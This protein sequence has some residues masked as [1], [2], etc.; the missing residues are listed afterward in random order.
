[1]PSERAVSKIHAIY[2]HTKP[3]DGRATQCLESLGIEYRRRASQDDIGACR[4]L[5]DLNGAPPWP[6]PEFDIAEHIELDVEIDE[7]GSDDRHFGSPSAHGQPSVRN[8]R[9]RG[10]GRRPETDSVG[11]YASSTV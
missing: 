8:K 2:P 11:L 3:D 10:D 4:D 5:E 6:G 1:M 9:L 7:P